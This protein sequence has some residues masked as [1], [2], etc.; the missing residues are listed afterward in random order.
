MSNPMQRIENLSPDERRSLLAQLLKKKSAQPRLVPTSFAQ[1]RLWFLDQLEP[2][3][4]T[5]NIPMALRLTG[6]LDYATL[7]RTINELLRRHETLRTGFAV[8]ELEPVQVILPAATIELEVVELSG[9]TE[10]E[11]E[12]AVAGQVREQ[13]GQPFE[14]SRAPL[15]RVQLLRLSATEHVL[16]WV[17]HHIISDGW[18]MGVLVREVAALYEAYSAGRESPL[19]EFPIQYGDYA[20]WQRERLQ[21]EVLAGELGYWQEQLRGA[22]A[23]LEL[24]TEKRRGGGAERWRGALSVSVGRGSSSGLE[25]VEPAGRS[26]AVHDVAERVRGAAGTLQRAGRSGDRDADSGADASGDGRVDRVFREHVGAASKGGRRSE[27][28]GSC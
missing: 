6:R 20:V 21:G 25:R 8:V 1:Q 13:A 27:L 3:S 22:P 14:L 11:R 15:V 18:S 2:G 16:I 10:A 12:A 4:A 5:Y 28:C 19:R 9:L 26:D 24:A 17:M 7:Q 23:V